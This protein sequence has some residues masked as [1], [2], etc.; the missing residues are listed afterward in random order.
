MEQNQRFKKNNMTNDKVLFINKYQP[1]YFH[2]FEMETDFQHFLSL[3]MDM[4]TINMLFVGAIGSGKTSLLN[5]FIRTYYG[6][7]KEANIEPFYNVLYINS[8]KEQGVHFYRNDVKTFCQTQSIVPKKKKIIIL[9]DLDLMHEQSQQVFRNCID[10]YS[11][12]VHFIASCSNIQKINENLQSRFHLIHLKSLTREKI[13]SIMKKIVRLEQ[14]SMDKEVEEFL[15]VLCD[16]SAKLL[17]LYLEKFKLLDEHITLD[18]AN[19]LCTN[20]SFSLFSQYTEAILKK[21]LELAIE[22]VYGIFDK[23]YSVIDFLDN[24]F[25]FI[26]KTRM[27]SEEMKYSI[28]PYICKYITIFHNVNEDEIELALFTNNLVSMIPPEEQTKNKK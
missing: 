5:A 6:L 8:L 28:I 27:I 15:L 22:I 24:Y 13:H 2:D 3:M 23:G 21:D 7:S 4:P 16:N 10:K 25:L 26:K 12:N 20:I 18:L 9:D 19:Q 17:I 14:I 1:H 11:H